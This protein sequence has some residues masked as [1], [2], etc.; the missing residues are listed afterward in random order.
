MEIGDF[1]PPKHQRGSF[2][3]PHCGV[4]SNQRWGNPIRKVQDINEGSTSDFSISRCD[5]CSKYAIW[6][7]KKLV[8]P[9]AISS[10]MPNPDLPEDIKEDFM[11]ARMI[12]QDSPRG[13][14]ALLRLCV[15]K[16]AKHLGEPGK[17]I[18]SDIKALVKKGLP[19]KVQQSLDVVRVIGNNAVHPGE[20]DLRDDIDTAEKLFELVNLIADVMISQPKHVREIYEELIPDTKRQAIEKRDGEG[21]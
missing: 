15:Q 16:I 4:L 17:N 9:K 1:V 19:V 11:E 20:I 6:I 14:A 3:C 5:H 13:A 2:T 18:N 8:H 21:E 7:N 12:A 10:P